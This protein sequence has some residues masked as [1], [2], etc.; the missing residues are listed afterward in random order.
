MSI[1]IESKSETQNESF[2]LCSRRCRGG[3]ALVHKC[4]RAQWRRRRKSHLW[5]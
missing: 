4:W 3:G 2:G 1:K 5:L